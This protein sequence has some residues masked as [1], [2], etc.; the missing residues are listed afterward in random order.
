[1]KCN[2]TC[3]RNPTIKKGDKGQPAVVGHSDNC[4]IW[5]TEAGG[6]PEAQDQLRLRARTTQLLAGSR[7]GTLSQNKQTNVS[8]EF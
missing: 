6:L 4:Y 3:S 5:E 1:M 7:M 2:K 8:L